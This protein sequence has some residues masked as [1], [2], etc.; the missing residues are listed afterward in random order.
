MSEFKGLFEPLHRDD[1]GCLETLE[2]LNRPGVTQTT[3]LEV[4]MCVCV[5]IGCVGIGCPSSRASLSGLHRDGD[6]G[7]VETLEE[8]N[9]SGVTQTTLLEGVCVCVP[10]LGV[11]Y[12]ARGDY[13]APLLLWPCSPGPRRSAQE[14]DMSCMSL[15]A[16]RLY[17]VRHSSPFDMT[18]DRP[19]D[20]YLLVPYAKPAGALHALV[21]GV[22]V[23]ATLF[24]FTPLLSQSLAGNNGSGGRGVW[25]LHC[26]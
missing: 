20:A 12:G 16:H 8:L 17:Y 24:P 25:R 4:C 26:R 10:G 6:S 3:L 18:N 22:Q 19:S 15:C 13:Q 23:P 5:G 7:R 2:E 9:R 21:S 14:Y 1:S 11:R